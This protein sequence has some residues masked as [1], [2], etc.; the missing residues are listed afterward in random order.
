MIE[1]GVARQ[2]DLHPDRLLETQFSNRSIDGV[3]RRVG[4]QNSRVVEI[5]VHHDDSP[6]R[7]LEI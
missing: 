7:D 3:D 2:P 6:G 5:G 1:R 4:D